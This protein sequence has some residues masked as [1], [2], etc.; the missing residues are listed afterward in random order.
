MSPPVAQIHLLEN[1][2]R[3][4]GDFFQI[5]EPPGISQAIKVDKLRDPRV[6]NDMVDEVGADKARA[7]GD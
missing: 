5:F 1:I 3:M 4:L 2:F 7:A 6:V